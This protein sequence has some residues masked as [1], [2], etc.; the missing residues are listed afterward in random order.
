MAWEFLWNGRKYLQIKYLIRVNIQNILRTGGGQDG[1]VGRPWA[2]LLSRASQNDNYLQR[3]HLCERPEP[4]IK[5][6]LQL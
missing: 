5:N 4:T 2:H 1:G 3:N 6:L